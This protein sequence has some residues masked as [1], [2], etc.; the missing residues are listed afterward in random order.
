MSGDNEN[1]AVERRETADG[2]GLG[3]IRR[4]TPMATLEFS[5]APGQAPRYLDASPMISALR[6]QPGDF[7]FSH[8]SLFHVPSKHRFHFDRRNNV[9]IEARCGCAML[10]MNPE[11]REELAATFRTW[12]HEYWTPVETNQEFASHFEAPSALGRL[13]RDIR[14]AFRRFRRREPVALSADA[15]TPVAASP[16]E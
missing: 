15:Q 6:F 2:I 10:E 16:A 9:S 1:S 3:F 11:Q 12:R 13:F 4:K 14:M 8:G 5:Y 7:E